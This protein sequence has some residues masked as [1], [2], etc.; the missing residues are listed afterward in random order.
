MC[1]ASLRYGAE[2]LGVDSAVQILVNESAHARYLP[3]R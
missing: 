1:R 2:V 3:V